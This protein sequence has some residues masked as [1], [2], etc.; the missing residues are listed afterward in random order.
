[1]SKGRIYVVID[2][3]DRVKHIVFFDKQNKKNRQIDVGHHSHIINGKLEKNHTHKG[4]FHSEGGTF[5][6]TQ[7]EKN[8]LIR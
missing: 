5:I 8:L 3:Q 6:M 7:A 2:N 4:Y 1:M